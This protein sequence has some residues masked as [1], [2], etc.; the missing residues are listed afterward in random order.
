[1]IALPSGRDLLVAAFAIAAFGGGLTYSAIKIY[2]R[3]NSDDFMKADLSKSRKLLVQEG[4][5]GNPQEFKAFL[6]EKANEYFVAKGFPVDPGKPSDTVGETANKARGVT[7][8][9]K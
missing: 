4:I 8:Q 2:E 1:M 7:P 6:S 5:A 3:F 9:P